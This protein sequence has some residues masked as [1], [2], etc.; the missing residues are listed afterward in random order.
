MGTIGGGSAGVRIANQMLPASWLVSRISCGR[1]DLLYTPPGR[2]HPQM[3]PLVLFTAPFGLS[4][5][6]ATRV[7]PTV[8]VR[9]IAYKDYTYSTSVVPA[10]T[11]DLPPII[12][13]PPIGVGIDRTFCGRFLEAWASDAGAG[14]SLHALD[15][16]GMGDSH[17]TWDPLIGRA[18]Q[19]KHPFLI[20]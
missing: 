20:Y 5:S 14:S 9:S 2:V 8:G 12:L 17:G 11:P 18:S 1:I 16:I 7:S 10:T 6:P 13:L 15:M 3:L 4:A 19:D